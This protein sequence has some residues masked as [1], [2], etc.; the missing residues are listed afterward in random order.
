MQPDKKIVVLVGGGRGIGHVLGQYLVKLNFEVICITRSQQLNHL[1]T[2]I[3][4]HYIDLKSQKYRIE[5]FIPKEA[6]AIIYLAHDGNPGF[7]LDGNCNQRSLQNTI[8]SANRLNIDKF[9][10]FSTS[11][12]LYD[13]NI[14]ASEDT[15]FQ[16]KDKYTEEK[17][18]GEQYIKENYNG[19]K[20]RIVRPS[21]IYGLERK[22]NSNQGLI[23]VAISHAIKDKEFIISVP[24]I[25]KRNFL[26]IND[27]NNLLIKIITDEINNKRFD[28]IN[29][30]SEEYLSLEYVLNKIRS[31][32]GLSWSSSLRMENGVRMLMIDHGSLLRST[33]AFDTYGW[34]SEWT[35]DSSLRDIKING[36]K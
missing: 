6:L 31:V 28:V 2:G 34:K 14:S 35:I 21:N 32:F 33:K 10:Y 17:I 23:D 19:K 11:G 15:E 18:K 1:N 13:P 25:L 3:R 29:V 20:I 30:A 7:Q 26:Y 9:I 5:K 36:F 12:K 8:D 22:I 16:I 27:L 24:K 4:Y